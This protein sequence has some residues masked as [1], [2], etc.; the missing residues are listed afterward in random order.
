[1]GGA[2]QRPFV[3]L[4]LEAAEEELP[5][6]SCALDLPEDGLDD[7]LAQSIAAALAGASE[8][9]AHG[10]D[11]RTSLL[12][13]AAIGVFGAAG[14]DAAADPA[15]SSLSDLLGRYVTVGEMVSVTAAS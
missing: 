9:Q 2:D 7:L 4:L 15:P 12:I 14:G 5:E 10:R 6:P 11:Q 1:V 3:F 8:L 13:L